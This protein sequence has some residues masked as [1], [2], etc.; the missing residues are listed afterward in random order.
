MDTQ[1]VCQKVLVLTKITIYCLNPIQLYLI[2]SRIQKLLCHSGR[3]S[4]IA[5]LFY[6]DITTL[7]L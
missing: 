6:Q 4:Y 3:Q 5:L 1:K 7:I 2:K